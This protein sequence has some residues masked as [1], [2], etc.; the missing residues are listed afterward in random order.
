ML[1]TMSA[2]ATPLS[3]ARPLDRWLCVP[4]FR[5]VC[6]FSALTVRFMW[7]SGKRVFDKTFAFIRVSTFVPGRTGSPIRRNRYVPGRDW[8]L[9]STS[10]HFTPGFYRLAAICS[11]ASAITTLGLIF[12]P[13][14]FPPADDFAA[15]MARVN[16]PLYRLYAWVYFV[17]PF[18]VLVA[19]LGVSLRLRREAASLVIP[20]LLAFLLWGVTEAA[21]QALTLMA[22]NPWRLAYLAGDPAVRTTMELRMAIYDG[23]WNAMYFLL[24]TG[25]FIANLLYAVALWRRRGFSRVVGAFYAGAAALTLQIIIVEVGGRQLVPDSIDFWLYPLIQ[26]LARTLIGVWV[27]VHRDENGGWVPP[28]SA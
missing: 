18:L 24:L 20:G 3:W 7:M 2:L 9:H 21:Q 6:L 4:T 1:R 13:G 27:W 25:F 16:D 14:W 22:F 28:R 10:M 12:L 15:R 17:H 26:P 11:F 5:W 8:A 23:L 19:A